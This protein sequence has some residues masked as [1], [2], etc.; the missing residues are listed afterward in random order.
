MC[1]VSVSIPCRTQNV[2]HLCRYAVFLFNVLGVNPIKSLTLDVIFGLPV[3]QREVQVGI[4]LAILLLYCDRDLWWV[5]WRLD[6]A[7]GVLCQEGRPLG[8]RLNVNNLR[9]Y[10]NPL[11]FAIM[12]VLIGCQSGNGGDLTHRGPHTCDLEN[13]QE[14]FVLLRVLIYWILVFITAHHGILSTAINIALFIKHSPLRSEP[15][16]GMAQGVKDAFLAYRPQMI[17]REFRRGVRVQIFLR[18]TNQGLRNEVPHVHSRIYND[19]ITSIQD[20]SY[21]DLQLA[22]LKTSYLF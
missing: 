6:K 11:L 22:V 14:V 12:Q 3:L 19:W 15:I 7:V 4:W 9:C 10:L 1:F 2:P 5:S 18:D 13:V 21:E 20:G 8:Y 17:L 16:G